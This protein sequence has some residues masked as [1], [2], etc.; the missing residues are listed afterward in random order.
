MNSS[1][2]V[3]IIGVL[4]I[5]LSFFTPWITEGVLTHSLVEVYGRAPPT[6][7][8]ILPLLTLLAGTAGIVWRKAN[9]IAGVLGVITGI[10]WI[11]GIEAY[12]A[13]LLES[14]E[15][16]ERFFSAI[17]GTGIGPYLTI[18]AGVVFL[19]AFVVEGRHPETLKT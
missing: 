10:I 17:L 11:V 5:I 1:K 14:S 9:V 19:I 15:W 16:S 7:L 12:K 3:S 6:I 2:I 18:V 13:E 4:L 8:T